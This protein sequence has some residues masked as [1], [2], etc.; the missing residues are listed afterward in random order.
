MVLF[1]VYVTTNEL[2]MPAIGDGELYRHFSAGARP[3]P[4]T[5]RQRIRLLT[6]LNP[7]NPGEPD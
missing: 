3:R 4:L 5:R 1:L 6:R 7:P 2:N